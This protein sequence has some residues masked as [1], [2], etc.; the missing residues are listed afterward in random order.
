MAELGF[1]L[2]QCD[3]R[4]QVNTFIAF[5]FLTYRLTVWTGPFLN[6][7]HT[8]KVENAHLTIE[9]CK[10]G[11]VVIFQANRELFK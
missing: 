4:N 7:T 5:S 8:L 6:F 10:D 1:K 11:L 9:K 2:R 3:S